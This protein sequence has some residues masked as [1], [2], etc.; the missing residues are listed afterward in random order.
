MTNL[1][2]FYIKASTKDIIVILRNFLILIFLF[3]QIANMFPA[4]TDIKKALPLNIKELPN[5]YKVNE[6]LYRGAQPGK[7]GFEKLKELGVKTII[8][9]RES[10]TD[11]DLIN[12]MGFN[13]VRLPMNAFFP[14]KEYFE[15][16]LQ[17]VTDEKYFP[18]YVHCRYG[19]DRT[20]TAVALYRIHVENIDVE[21]AIDEMEYGG[22]GF[23]K[24][25][26]NLKSFIK[27]FGN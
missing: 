11:G 26:Q 13:Y 6:N 25:Y 4:D 22:F 9:F 20:G 16:Y 8:N 19:A 14:K 12:G 27:N 23:H 24:I 18:V 2:Y 3:L 21:S 1:W 15:E 7:G 10:D 17:I 5:C